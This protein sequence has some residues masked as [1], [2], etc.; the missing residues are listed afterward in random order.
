VRVRRGVGGRDDEVLVHE[1]GSEERAEPL[2][3]VVT[4][5]PPDERGPE[6]PRRVHPGAVERP[7]GQHVGAEQEAHGERRDGAHAPALRVDHGGVVRVHEPERHDG[8]QQD[9]VPV[10]HARRQ[11]EPRRAHP[12]RHEA[13]EERRRDGAQDLRH[14]VEDRPDEGDAPARDVH[15]DGHRCGQRHQAA[16]RAHV[17]VHLACTSSGTYNVQSSIGAQAAVRV[18]SQQCSVASV[19]TEGEDGALGG[20]DED[21]GG[22]ELG[23]GGADGVRVGRVLAAPHREPHARAHL[24]AA[25]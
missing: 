17:L 4:P 3:P 6:H 9:G 15:G 16:H 18:E 7:A 8:L 24:D 20:E 5:P 22:E 14:P 11:H 13:Q 25:E 2:H 12:A 19:R 10:A 1:P 21:G 23:N